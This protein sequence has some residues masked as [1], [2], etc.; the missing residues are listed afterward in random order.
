VT[1]SVLVVADDVTGANAA[2]AGF[3]RQGLRAVVI[4]EDQPRSTLAEFAPRFD[5]LVATTGSRHRPPAQAAA[6]VTALIEAGWP[7]RLVSNRID[8]TLRGNVGPST[9][10]A[11]AAVRGLTGRRAL[12]LCAPAHPA[13][14]RQTVGGQ[15]LLGG[16]R[17]E[18]TEL[19][20]DQGSPI[21]HSDVA[22]LVTGGTGLAPAHLPLQAVTG[23]P[24]ELVRAVR[25]A[26]EA[27]ADVLIADALTEDHLD[28]V[29]RAA[30]TATRGRE[31]LVWVA[32]D[33]G[34]GALALARALG[35]GVGE[36]DRSLPVLALSASATE[37]TRAQLRRLRMDVTVHVV[38]PRFHAAG[39]LDVAATAAALTGALGAARTHE[40]VLLA[41]VLDRSDL[42]PFGPEGAAALTRDLADAAHQALRARPVGGVYITGGDMT[43]ALL[44]ALGARGLD[45]DREVVPLAVS[46][47]LVG[48]A[49]D[50]LPVVTKGGLIGDAATATACVRLLQQTA[51]ANS[52]RV[53]T[54]DTGAA[55]QPNP[56]R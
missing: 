8:T 39:P 6:G 38:E 15:Q 53:A 2:A 24:S 16:V 48:G 19:R 33:S 17:L 44:A 55:P 9:A 29:A 21:T 56:T 47:A 31:D 51:R 41:T 10:A 4:G 3:A 52:R 5:V 25:A 20:Y 26:I 13:A 7:V 42:R 30:V 54:A 49:W 36:E 1:A 27:G 14:G 34:P 45:V 43:A 22:G 46:G 28:R 37:L 11:L 23:P 35:I 40:A 50:G 32:V 12:A 18:E